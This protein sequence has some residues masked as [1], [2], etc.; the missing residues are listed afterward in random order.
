MSTHNLCF[1]A[2]IRKIGIPMHTPVLLI[3]VGFE[4]VYFTRTCFPDEIYHN[5][6]FSHDCNEFS[7]DILIRLGKLPIDP[8]TEAMSKSLSF[9]VESLIQ[10][11]LL[12]LISSKSIK[13]QLAGDYHI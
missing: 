12:P 6:P 3:K 4:G 10:N 1:G 11:R 9:Y 2:K 7:S 8:V 5:R 13:I